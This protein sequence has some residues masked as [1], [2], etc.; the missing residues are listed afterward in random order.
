MKFVFFFLLVSFRRKR[1]EEQSTESGLLAERQSEF[2]RI[3]E[4]LAVS[5]ILMELVPWLSSICTPFDPFSM[6][7]IELF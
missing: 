7:F 6:C 3:L 5:R 1:V 2:R 4:D